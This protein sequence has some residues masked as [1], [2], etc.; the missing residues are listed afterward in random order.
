[1]GTLI[2][3]GYPTKLVFGAADHT[4]V[5]CG[6]GRRGWKCFGGKSGGKLIRRANGSTRRANAI[7]TKDEDGGLKCYGINGVCHQAANRILFPASMTVEGARG[8]GVSQGMFGTYGRE[9]FGPCR[10]PFHR[11]PDVSGDLA[12]CRASE[13]DDRVEASEGLTVERRADATFVREQAAIYDARANW[14]EKPNPDPDEIEAFHLELFDHMLQFKLGPLLLDDVRAR[15]LEIR[16]EVERRFLRI[17]LRHAEGELEGPPL[18]EAVNGLAVDL[19]NGV[20]A[21]T[22]DAQY[23]SLFGLK[24]YEVVLVIDPDILPYG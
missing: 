23:E 11:H 20:A 16:R 7:A 6:T 17:E 21:A 18:A 8:Y 15:L 3:K 14:L 12:N 13:G 2:A 10:S 1:M 5:E 24:K 9:G 4:Y 19:Q 22:T